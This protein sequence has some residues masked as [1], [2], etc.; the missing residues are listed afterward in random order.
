MLADKFKNYKII[1]ASE[2]PRRNFL[3]KEIGLNF[4][5]KVN[6]NIDEVYP[7]NID[8]KNIPVYLS[9][10]KSNSWD[11]KLN[12]NTIVITADTIVLLKNKVI[13][14]P[15]NSI[16]AEQM[17]KEL[18]GEMHLVITGVCIKSKFKKVT[19]D[20]TSKVFFKK[21]TN[22]EIKWYVENY[23]PFDKA[24]AY[25]IQEWI[26][27]IGIKKIEGSYFNVMGLPIHR[28]YEELINF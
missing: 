11:N 6:G 20:D 1:L 26:G 28:V 27:Y 10:L 12:D 17:L 3:L 21:L 4:E 18:S 16:E 14:K 25:G 8:K 5:V 22:D 19:F 13:N 23:K 9:E 7:D 2:S 15:A 24:G